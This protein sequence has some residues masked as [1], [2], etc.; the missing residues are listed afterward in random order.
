[1]ALMRLKT[2][3]DGLLGRCENFPKF[4]GIH[5]GELPWIAQSLGELVVG[6]VGRDNGFAA[7]NRDLR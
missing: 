6:I 4:V 5:F 3:Q 2:N 1:M 7:D